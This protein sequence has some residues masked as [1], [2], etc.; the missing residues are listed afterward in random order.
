MNFK[1]SL[2][3]L[4]HAQNE[5]LLYKRLCHP[6]SSTVCQKLHYAAQVKPIHAFSRAT[7]KTRLLHTTDSKAVLAQILLDN[8]KLWLWEKLSQEV[9]WRITR[10]P[11][12]SLFHNQLIRTISEI[13]LLYNHNV[14]LMYLVAFDHIKM[15]TWCPDSEKWPT[16]PPTLAFFR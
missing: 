14:W 12:H 2:A 5:K 1:C 8:V 16:W 4:Y 15:F 6:P 10:I 7:A 3:S 13:P 11:T 9:W